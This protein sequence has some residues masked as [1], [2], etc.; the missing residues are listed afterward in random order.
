LTREF[1]KK[2][3]TRADQRAAH[4]RRHAADA[5]ELARVDAARGN[6]DAERVH[7]H[8]ADAHEGAARVTE[9]TAALYRNRVKHLTR[10]EPRS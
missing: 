8:E 4:A 10:A 6:H 1:L 2:L 7:L 3:A 5:R 9:Q